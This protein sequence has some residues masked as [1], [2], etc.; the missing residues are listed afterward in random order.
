M[1]SFLSDQA[2]SMLAEQFNNL[3]D[4]FARDIVVYKEAKK[5][6]ISTDP[7][8]NYIYNETGGTASIQNTPQKQIFKARV[9]Y[10]DN[11]DMEYF[12]ELETSHKIKRVDS[13]SRVR[14]KLKKADYDYIREAKRVELDGRMFFIDSDA[15]AH[16]LFNV[17][18]YTL[19]LKP[20]EAK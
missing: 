9:L 6:V 17:D 8:Y 4:T 10:D 12:G 18:F 15:R 3:H 20:V 13:S 16:G 11:R 5:V 14:I 7:N 19:Y 2:K 1:P